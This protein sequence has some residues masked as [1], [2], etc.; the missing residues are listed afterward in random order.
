MTKSLIRAIGT[1]FSYFFIFFLLSLC[2]FTGLFTDLFIDLLLPSIS[3]Y[4]EKIDKLEGTYE[5]DPDYK[6]FL[7]KEALPEVVRTCHNLRT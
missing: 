6:N 5:E 2:L 1:F 3:R 7:I 4:Q